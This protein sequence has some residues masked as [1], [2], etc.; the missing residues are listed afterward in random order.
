MEMTRKERKLWLEQIKRI[1]TMQKQQRDAE[2]VAQLDSFIEK[3]Q[4]NMP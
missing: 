3:Q 2:T 1:H 4:S